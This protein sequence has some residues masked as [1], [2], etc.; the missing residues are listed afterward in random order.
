MEAWGSFLQVGWGAGLENNLVFENN[1]VYYILFSMYSCNI[2]VTN[3]K[4]RKVGWSWG[5]EFL[6]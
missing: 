1:L 5:D 4:K 3:V 2:L 6:N